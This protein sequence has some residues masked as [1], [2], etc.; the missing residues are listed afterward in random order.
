ML[1]RIHFDGTPQLNLTLNGDARDLHSF[2]VR[3]KAWAPAAQTPWFQARDLQLTADLTAPANAPTNCDPAWSFW[4][5]AQPYRLE[6]SA[7]LTQLQ[8]KKLNAEF[9]GCGGVWSA[10]QLTVTNLSAELGGGRL[11]AG[12]KLNVATRELT[13]TNA[14]CFDLAARAR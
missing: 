11:A 10:P 5:N 6:W 13:F 1:R 12:L 8:S 2:S 9:V 14:S 7:R 3:L 4:T